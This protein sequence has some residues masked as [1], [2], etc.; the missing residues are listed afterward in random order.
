[1]INETLMVAVGVFHL[2]QWEEVESSAEP[3]LA[4]TKGAKR[5]AIEPSS[6]AMT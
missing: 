1:M 4:T 3:S 2:V 6:E 5:S